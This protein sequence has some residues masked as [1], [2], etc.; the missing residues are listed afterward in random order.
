MY[1][2][3]SPGSV[4]WMT[5]EPDTPNIPAECTVIIHD[6]D[7]ILTVGPEEDEIFASLP[8]A[9]QVLS[10]QSSVFSATFGLGYGFK[11]SL[12]V[13]RAQ[14]LRP[15]EPA[16]IYLG[17]DDPD[18]LE[19]VLK[20]LH[21]RV[22]DLPKTVGFDTLVGLAEICEKY[23]LH[24]PLYATARKWCDGI[25]ADYLRYCV[26][27]LDWIYLRRSHK[28]SRVSDL[29]PLS[30]PWSVISESG[31]SPGPPQHCNDD[32]FTT[33]SMKFAII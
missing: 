2:D 16:V 29:S 21:H 31:H 25:S 19:L 11:S 9:S 4:S 5:D 33:T 13:R 27:A 1:Y 18:A 24:T 17:D 26:Y 22:K 30:I 23:F 28:L 3:G 7:L 12:S 14:L 20:V 15:M 6:V 8:V 10:S 32:I